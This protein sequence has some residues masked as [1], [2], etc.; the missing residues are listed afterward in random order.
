MK[1]AP[2]IQELEYGATFMREARS[3]YN[4]HLFDVSIFSDILKDVERKRA[5]TSDIRVHSP[6]FR[7]PLNCC[8]SDLL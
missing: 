7:S 4:I 8:Q 6:F 3:D 5:A 2:R 1:R